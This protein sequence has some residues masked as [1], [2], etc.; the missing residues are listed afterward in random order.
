MKIRLK[1]IGINEFQ[2]DVSETDL[3]N[4]ITF[5]AVVLAIV[6]ESQQVPKSSPKKKALV[7]SDIAADYAMLIYL[8]LTFI[9]MYHVTLWQHGIN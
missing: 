3:Y 7:L 5:R 2:G 9:G 8:V 4:S 6:N 1:R